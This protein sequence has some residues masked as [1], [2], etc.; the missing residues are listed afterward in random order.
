MTAGALQR[1][2]VRLVLLLVGFAKTIDSLRAVAAADRDASR[3]HHTIV[4]NAF[5]K[6]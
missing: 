1:N 2:G 3:T 4:T 6:W 5:V